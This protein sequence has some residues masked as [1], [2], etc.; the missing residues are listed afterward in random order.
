MS[1]H[2][3]GMTTSPSPSVPARVAA[4][5]PSGGQFA[6]TT[7]AEATQ[8]VLHTPDDYDPAMELR[9]IADASELVSLHSTPTGW[10]TLSARAGTVTFESP[11]CDT[12][13]DA[14][15]SVLEQIKAERVVWSE[16]LDAAWDDDP[17][18][19]DELNWHLDDADTAIEELQQ[20]LDY[21]NDAEMEADEDE[22]YHG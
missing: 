7:R 14:I 1:G 12:T 8:V 15:H 6:A 4:G 22:D 11:R 21:A 9:R 17:Y 18:E 13:S 19:C 3:P 2:L 16:E 5:V 10:T 20:M